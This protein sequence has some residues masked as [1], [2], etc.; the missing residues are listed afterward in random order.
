MSYET[1]NNGAVNDSKTTSNE[2]QWHL[3][4][5]EEAGRLKPRRYRLMAD[6]S[7]WYDEDA[8]LEFKPVPGGAGSEIRRR[9]GFEPAPNTGDAG[10]AEQ[11][12]KS[13]F[14]IKEKSKPV[15]M[16]SEAYYGLAGEVVRI[17]ESDTEACPE[18]ILVQTLIAVGNMIG[19]EV[20][21]NQGD[22]QRLVEF[23][24][25]VGPSGDGKGVSW[26]VVEGLL[27][28]I[29]PQWTKSCIKKG[30]ATG[31][32]LVNEIRDERTVVLKGKE[33]KETGE[34]KTVVEPGVDDK[35]AFIL[36]QEFSRLLSVAKRQGNPLSEVV[37]NAFDSP[38]TL[39]ALSKTN[40][41]SASRP[42]ISIMGH[43]TP[44][45]LGRVLNGADRTNGFANRF[46]WI[47]TYRRQELP[48]ATVPEWSGEKYSTLIA[49]FRR[50][51]EWAKEH[52]R[53][54]TWTEAGKAAWVQWYKTQGKRP[55]EMGVILNRWKSHVLRLSMI[56]AILDCRNV[57]DVKHFNAAKA[58]WDYAVQS[59]MRIFGNST[60]NKKAD[61]LSAKLQRVGEMGLTAINAFFKN[62][63]S[64]ADRDDIIKA[65]V[66]N[67]AATIDLRSSPTGRALQVLRTTA[68][69]LN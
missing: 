34:A 42:H 5:D 7:R 15:P 43:I 35:R 48:F 46:L 29:D 27:Q 69:G 52:P 40:P 22:Y 12:I 23:G 58:V 9:L 31:E 36:E 28:Q 54:M 13:E 67:G 26:S 38:V 47:E 8:P 4:T 17:A 6:G 21:R 19:R 53:S 45:E 32:A 66:E 18:A 61:Q 25:L 56:Y 11:D 2:P 62:N 33:D 39:S 20:W 63:L 55:G 65:L 68:S 16:R 41:I 1:K 50:A 10:D 3:E 30:V 37:R 64:Q 59:A 60:G 57:I 14:A 49:N 44:S 51:I 24:C